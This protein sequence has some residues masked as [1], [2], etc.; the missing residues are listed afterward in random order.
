MQQ[1]SLSQEFSGGLS[2]IGYLKESIKRI[3]I[4]MGIFVFNLGLNYLFGWNFDWEKDFDTVLD[5]L[6]S[7]PLVVVSAFILFL[8]PTVRRANDA[9]ISLWLVAIGEILILTP[10]PPTSESFQ[11]GEAA[12]FILVFIPTIIWSLYLTFK[13][14]A[15][16]RESMRKKNLTN[17]Q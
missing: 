7:D 16:W 3:I 8:G 15:I 5:G 2:R 9:E 11:P 12:Y 4:L 13:P 6:S 17:Y 1:F 14:G 10:A